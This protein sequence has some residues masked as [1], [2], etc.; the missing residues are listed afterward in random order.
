MDSASF[1]Y[2]NMCVFIYARTYILCICMYI[3]YLIIYIHSNAHI[4]TCDTNNQRP[5]EFLPGFLLKKVFLIFVGYFLSD[6]LLITA[7]EPEE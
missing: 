3:M 5:Q 1:I 6:S 7:Y 2:I 4:L